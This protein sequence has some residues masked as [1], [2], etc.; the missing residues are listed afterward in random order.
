M[1]IMCMNHFSG[2]FTTFLK[3]VEK[4]K[5]AAVYANDIDTGIIKF[6]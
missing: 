1:H 2:R 4:Y 6:Q 3:S 5:K